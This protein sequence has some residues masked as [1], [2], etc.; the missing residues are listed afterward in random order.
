MKKALDIREKQSTNEKGSFKIWTGYFHLLF[1]VRRRCAALLPE[2]EDFSL[3][4]LSSCPMSLTES[5]SW[6]FGIL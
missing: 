1:G 4:V 6:L 3:L 5:F 2:T